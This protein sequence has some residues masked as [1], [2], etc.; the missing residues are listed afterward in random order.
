MFGNIISRRLEIKYVRT[1]AQLIKANAKAQMR[2][3]HGTCICLENA[4][5]LLLK[6]MSR[7]DILGRLES[8][9]TTSFRC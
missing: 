6:K 8:Y 4:S 9:Y 7:L 2:S 1:N 3:K 5:S